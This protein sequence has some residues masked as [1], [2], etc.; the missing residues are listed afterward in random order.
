MQVRLQGAAKAEVVQRMRPQV[1]HQSADVDRG[2]LQLLGKG[3][4]EISGPPRFAVD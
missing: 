1:V 2:R 4:E 3:G